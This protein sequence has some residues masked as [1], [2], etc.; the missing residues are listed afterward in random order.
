VLVSLLHSFLELHG[1]VGCNLSKDQRKE[2][3]YIKL[4]AYCARHLLRIM[5]RSG[6]GIVELGKQDAPIKEANMNILV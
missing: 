6:L 4:Q 5:L 1:L 3:T 2:S